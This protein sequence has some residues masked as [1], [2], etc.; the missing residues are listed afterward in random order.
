MQCSYKWMKLHSKSTQLKGGRGMRA[1]G[2]EIRKQKQHVS[3]GN[4]HIFGHGSRLKFKGEKK[5]WRSRWRGEGRTGF[6]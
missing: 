1:K 5:H 3:S 2:G 6:I 4:L